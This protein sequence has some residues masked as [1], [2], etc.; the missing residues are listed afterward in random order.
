MQCPIKVAVIGTGFAKRVHIPA[1]KQIADAKVVAVVGRRL[2][3]A[4]TCAQE[5]DIPCASDNYHTML[6]E[7]RPDLTIIAS[8]VSLHCDMARA[9]L[10]A[11]SHVICEKPLAMNVDEAERLAV[12]AETSGL[13]HVVNHQLRFDPY[14][15]YVK[16][17]LDKGF[18]GRVQHVTITSTDGFR[19]ASPDH[20]YSWWSDETAGGG[21]LYARASHY[22][23]LV[24]WWLGP[25][26]NVT[27]QLGT[28]VRERPSAESKDVIQ[29]TSDDQYTV[30][31]QTRSGSLVVLF[32]SGV[33][34]HSSSER[35]E[36]TGDSGTLV[37]DAD[38]GLWGAVAGDPLTRLTLPSE[39]PP[40]SLGGKR[41]SED[42]VR[43]LRTTIRALREEG[44]PENAATF[45]TAVQTQKVL[46]AAKQS[47]AERK[48]VVVD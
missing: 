38:E 25:L 3:H 36:I 39:D 42:C 17:L 32:G 5:F 48:W 33:S 21:A 9:A 4:R 47:W 20:R 27:A 37:F 40:P 8:P 16:H 44:C 19:T 7:V 18:T 43:L 10:N 34:H 26:V 46:A 35:I 12:Q 14:L 45:R 23:D 6:A 13:V 22:I 15:S 1:L 28:W 24:Q 31:G 2:D 29:V 11:G 41:W 30:M